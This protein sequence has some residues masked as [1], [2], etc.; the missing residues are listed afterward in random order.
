MKR[1]KKILVISSTFPR[2]ESDSDPPFVFKLIERITGSFKAVVLC[3]HAPG[4]ERFEL[5]HGIR[6][7][8][9]RYFFT[10]LQTLAYDGGILE[11]LKKN[12]WRYCLVPFFV[13][14]EIMSTVRLL[15][16]EK[17]DVIWP[18]W[19]LPQGLA[20]VCAVKLTRSKVPII[21]TLHGS[22]VFALK[23]PFAAA[24][25]RYVLK[26]SDAV[27][28][29]SEAMRSAVIRLGVAGDRIRVIPMG[30]NL[31]G[32]FVPP[33]APRNP[34][35]ILF[36]GRIVR[37]KGLD[38]LLEAFST[39]VKK[40]PDATLSVVGSGQT[41]ADAQKYVHR[42][43]LSD[44]VRFLGAVP[45]DRL[46]GIY[47]STEIVVFPSVGHEGFGLVIVEALGCEC[48]VIATDF[49]AVHDILEHKRTGII[50]E[51]KNAAALA[52]SIAFLFENPGLRKAIGKNG[53]QYVLDRYDWESIKK[54]YCEVLNDAAILYSPAP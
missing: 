12:K 6:I 3:P 19:L 4:A 29:V 44:R 49:Q 25:K 8:R 5:F 16:R 27:V 51:R 11:K 18:H 54:S 46:P 50:V 21:C 40:Y 41:A 26:Q 17:Y 38:Y 33:S 34:R 9:F 30:V 1:E 20:A 13:G 42:T 37:D 32:Q 35:S 36:V 22:D 7:E 15:R 24:L 47:Q 31:A 14:G 28:V 43:G 23:G 53:R 39:V 45:N 52:S 48:A 2:W 10:R